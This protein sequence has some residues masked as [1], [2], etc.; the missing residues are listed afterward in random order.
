MQIIKVCWNQNR[1]CRESC[2]HIHYHFGC[3]YNSK[4]DYF[5]IFIFNILTYSLFMHANVNF[6]IYYMIFY[7]L[8]RVENNS[9]YRHWLVL[10]PQTKPSVTNHHLI[11][12]LCI[13]LYQ[14]WTHIVSGALSLISNLLLKIELFRPKSCC[15]FGS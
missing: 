10:L 11:H 4:I 2:K 1:R 13:I 12:Q 6:H 3:S 14:N 5:E 9:S 8:H 7:P 15:I